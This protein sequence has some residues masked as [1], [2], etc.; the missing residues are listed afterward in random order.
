MRPLLRLLPAAI[1]ALGNAAFGQQP[2]TIRMMG[3]AWQGI[4]PKE[5]T[6]P[7]SL[8]RRAV[9][10]AF[11]NENP[12][13]TVV[14]AGGLEMVGDDSD[15]GFLMSMAGDTAPDV[16]YV[17]FRQYYQY[18]DEGFCRP[19]D[20]LI[21]QD[22]RVLDRINP[23]I[24]GV[25]KSYDGH[26]YAMPWY[27]VALA[28]YYRR[29][30][31]QAA[32]LDPGKPP[33]TWDEFYKDGQKLVESKPGLSGFAFGANPGDKAYL[34]IDFL[35]QAGGEAVVPTPSGVWKAA[36]ATPQGAT[37]L[38]FYRKLVR[39]TWTG[40]DGKTYGPMATLTPDLVTLRREDKVA[41]WFGYTTDL[42]LTSDE[43]NPANV[44]IAALPAGPG[45]A[46]NEINAGMW[47][48]NANVKDPVKLA[49]CWRFIK[50]FAGQEAARVNTARM[51]DM[52]LGALCNP[53][54][55]RKFGYTDVLSQVDPQYV[56]ANEE[57]FSH[58][59][60]EPYGRNCQQVYLVMG[61]ALDR[62]RLENTPA[63]A[64]LKDV[65][66]SMDEK[67]LGY[68]P[69]DVMAKRRSWATGIFAFVMCL[70]VFGLVA[71]WRWGRTQTV[72]VVERLPAGV[73]RRK[74][75]FFVALLVG[76]AAALI[77]LWAYFPLARGMEIGFQDYHLIAPT[78]WV[79]LDNF[80]AV[81]C[82]PIFYKSLINSF[83]YV[84]LTILIGFGLPI[85]LALM[86]EAVP[87][88]RS[89][90]RTL[91][92]LPAMTSPLVIAL[93]WKQLYDKSA[94]GLLNQ[95]L[96]P[97]IHV[98]NGP[99]KALGWAPIK[100]THDWLGD[101]SLAML[102]VVLPGIWAAMGPG[103]I[104]YSA[105]LKSVPNEGYEAADID[106]ATWWH[107]IRFI[108]LP[109]LRPLILINLLGV[110]IGGFKAFDNVFAMTMGGPLN[111]T[112]TMGLEIWQNAFMFLKFGYATAAAWVMGAILVGFTLVQVK[113]LTRMKF[114]T[115]KS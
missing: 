6:D 13:V 84:G 76:P 91:Y 89:F 67:L 98:L 22:P 82:A 53:I 112:H 32:G 99:V 59:H 37:A 51:V 2:V 75:R 41:M 45:G 34:W 115:A 9:F 24:M 17:N 57:E 70:V 88:G 23:T 19:L 28:M 21:A 3:G 73:S 64:I 26:V 56:Q 14:N 96:L 105:A 69:P 33:R 36:L 47:A 108:T 71:L 35:W 31:F 78:K 68:T 48:I 81:F 95:I 58:G 55:L 27:Q 29:D 1:V 94:T 107:K 74:V 40:P 102:A 11:H 103:S 101:P 38:D 46:Q 87:V 85:A 90:L 50:F 4:P 86:L 25:V 49:A 93:L 80:I 5:A 7:R 92:Y 97:I 52:G 106:G 77:L 44:G 113:S 114:S 62:A 15:S 66:K 12:D 30:M 18:V 39:D 61:D 20:D 72:D 110:F 104:L 63:L 83:L 8:A 10:E 79:G 16:F 42:M 109:A 54:Y 60:P 65:S 43:I 100:E 111:A